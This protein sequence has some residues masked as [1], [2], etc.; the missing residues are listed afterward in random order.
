MANS[1]Q[2]QLLKSGLVD[3][4]QLKQAKSKK[5][6]QKR[7]GG[8]RAPADAE[9]RAAAEQAAAEK[10]RR[11]QELN[12]EREADRQRKAEL[13]ALWHLVRDNRLS[14][15]GGDVAYN[16]TDGSALKR[17]Y[18][19]ADQQKAIAG[20]ELAIVRHDDF[21]EIVPA[22]VAERTEQTD[23]AILVVWNKPGEAD[24]DDPYAGF[25]VPDDLM[26]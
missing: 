12:R 20:G 18:V 16:F 21:Y 7:A 15:D 14:R 10:R 19:T 5:R 11:D 24:P 8:G 9:R 13:V 23:P 6:K 4:Q 25:E 2:D 3:E 26:W 1:L 22:M 17:L